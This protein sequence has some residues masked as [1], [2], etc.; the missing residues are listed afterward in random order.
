M[1]TAIKAAKASALTGRLVTFGIS[2]THPATGFGYI[3][4]AGKETKG[5]FKVKNFV[6]KPKSARA[7][8]MLASGKFFWNSGMFVFSAS[9][10]IKECKRLAPKVF[11]AARGALKQSKKDLDFIRLD[12]ESFSRSPDISVDYAIF[13]KTS[14][15]S[16]VPAA[17]QWSDLG[18]WDSVWD[19]GKRDRKNN[20]KR[21]DIHL[22]KTRNSLVLSEK[23]PIAVHGMNNIAVIASEDAIYV[24]DLSKS[25]DVGEIV[26]RLRSN[27]ETR[28]L[29]ETHQTSY[30]PWGGYSSVL[31][32]DRF[33]VKRLFVKPGKKLSLQKHHHRSEHWIV[34][35]GTA[36]VQIDE[37]SIIL[38][39]NESVFIPQG[40]VHRLA[41]PGR[42]L[43]ELIEVQ[44]GSYLGE[45][46]II[47]L[48]D[49]FG[50]N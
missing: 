47:R 9:V 40:A 41:N 29:T 11:S 18:A 5:S 42:I 20:L 17:I 1:F 26:R 15:A 35:H 32:G 13:E 38:R 3:E 2:P 33:Q 6:E 7:K 39:E 31:F 23:L 19:A 12:A 45:D 10:F 36:D 28:H 49:E 30:R 37:K 21:G 14:L 48:D 44:T 43:L 50:R 46:D 25:Q 22:S 27:K 8:E 4:A 24:G 34:V 16:V